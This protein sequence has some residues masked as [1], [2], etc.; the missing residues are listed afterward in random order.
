MAWPSPPSSRPPLPS[1]ARGSTRTPRTSRSSATT[2]SPTSRTGGRS[3]AAP[4]SSTSGR[5]HGGGSP[6][7][8]TGPCSPAN[9]T[10]TPRSSA[11]SARVAWP[12]ATGPDRSRGLGHRRRPALPPLQQGGAGRDR[13]RSEGPHRC[14]RGEVGSAG[15]DPVMRRRIDAPG[16]SPALASPLPGACGSA[17]AGRGRA[18]SGTRRTATVQKRQ[19]RSSMTPGLARRSE[20]ISAGSPKRSRTAT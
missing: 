18:R 6:A 7:P 17:P 4:T 20:S 5:T 11:A 9:P 1:Q 3:K 13:G 2:R 8:S 14:R 15:Q 16:C 10:A 12:S 19:E